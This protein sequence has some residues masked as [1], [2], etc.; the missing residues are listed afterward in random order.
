MK[1]AQLVT[2]YIK[3]LAESAIFEVS[4]IN[5]LNSGLIAKRLDCQTFHIPNR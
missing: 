4:A 2:R 3:H 1:N 5:K